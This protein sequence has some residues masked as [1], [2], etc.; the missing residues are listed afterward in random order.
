[1]DLSRVILTVLALVLAAP[2]HAQEKQDPKPPKQAEAKKAEPPKAPQNAPTKPDQPK[3]D[4]PEDEPKAAAKK[5]PEPKPIPIE[6]EL[7]RGEALLP[8]SATKSLRYQ[9]K[10]WTITQPEEGEEPAE[11]ESPQRNTVTVKLKG[12]ELIDGVKHKVLA[13]F[14]NGELDQQEFYRI[15]DG[16]LAVSR[17]IFGSE[18]HGLAFDTLSED[19]PQLILKKTM[20]KGD[21]WEWKGRLGRSENTYTVMI[22]GAE[23]IVVEG[24]PYK[25]LKVVNVVESSDESKCTAQRWY[26]PGIGMVRELTEVTTAA[27]SFRTETVLQRIEEIKPKKD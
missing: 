20:K 2:A 12:E 25:T 16:A 7:A 21:R 17:R 6:G 1:M 8:M 4:A 24:K 18:K 11:T 9:V 19:G 10:V 27:E 22:M 23:L 13:Y 3:K 26:S 5:A 14:L 15:D